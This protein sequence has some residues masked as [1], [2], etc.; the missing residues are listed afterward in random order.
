MKYRYV[1]NSWANISLFNFKTAVNETETINTWTFRFSYKKN[2]NWFYTQ[3]KTILQRTVHNNKFHSI[4][5]T[6]VIGVFNLIFIY[7]NCKKWSH[8]KI[9][10]NCL[11]AKNEPIFSVYWYINA[12][13]FWSFGNFSKT[14]LSMLVIMLFCKS[15]EEKYL[16]QILIHV[17][18]LL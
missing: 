8:F 13:S 17:K 6:N 12:Y 7:F 5:L 2:M 10:I 15:L 16:Q 11:F 3:K 18:H 1:L 9:T 14:M 4:P